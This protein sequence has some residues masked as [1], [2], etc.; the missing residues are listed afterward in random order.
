M[1]GGVG[2]LGKDEAR[3][4]ARTRAAGP[5]I[6]SIIYLQVHGKSK[7]PGRPEPRVEGSRRAS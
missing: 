3:S 1:G 4:V 2:G 7:L 6:T 5:N